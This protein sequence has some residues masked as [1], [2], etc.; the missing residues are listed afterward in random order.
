MDVVRHLPLSQNDRSAD[1]AVPD[2]R[3]LAAELVE[4]VIAPTAS[5]QEAKEFLRDAGTKA[6]SPDAFAHAL[7]TASR[8]PSAALVRIV[9]AGLVITDA[10]DTSA[11]IN[12]RLV[13]AAAFAAS[14]TA[15]ADRRAA[16]S[17]LTVTASDAGWSFGAG[18]IAAAPALDI[19]RFLVGLS[20]TPPRPQRR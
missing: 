8:L 10:H 17:G 1:A 16:I 13:G 12:P 19:L 3:L 9:R 20:D 6:E 2:R 4:A 5:T 7:R 14:T 18:P 15:P 11:D